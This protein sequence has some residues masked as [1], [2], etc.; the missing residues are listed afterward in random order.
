MD[1][2]PIRITFRPCDVTPAENA[3][4]NIGDDG[5]ISSP[6]TT[7]PGSRS[8]CKKRA[9]ATPVANAKS[10]VISTSTS[11]RMSYALKIE[12]F[13]LFS[14]YHLATRIYEGTAR[15]WPRRPSEICSDVAPALEL[16]SSLE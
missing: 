13:I 7:V 9:K 15:R 4:A 2:K 10:A 6:I 3:S 11:P 14:N 5:R 16:L 8:C 12:I 1:A